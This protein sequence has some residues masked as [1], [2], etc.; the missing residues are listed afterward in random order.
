M[1]IMIPNPSTMPA[2]DVLFSQMAP[3]IDTDVEA[4]AVLQSQLMDVNAVARV[5]CVM[6]VRNNV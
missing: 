2:V 4:S 3:I 1:A 5:A 6:D